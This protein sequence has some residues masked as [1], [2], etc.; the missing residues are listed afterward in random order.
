M[1]CWV[2]TVVETEPQARYDLLLFQYRTFSGSACSFVK[3]QVLKLW[4][5]S[6]YCSYL[7]PGWGSG[8]CFCTSQF[9][10]T[11]LC[12]PVQET[13]MLTTMPPQPHSPLVQVWA[14]LY[15]EPQA[16]ASNF[17]CA[18]LLLSYLIVLCLQSPWCSCVSWA[19]I[20]YGTL[21][22]SHLFLFL[23]LYCLGSLQRK[24]C[25]CFFF[26]PDHCSRC[27]L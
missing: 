22:C 24:F 27:T 11:W 14:F 20:C 4:L 25:E 19:S 3:M 21:Y 18:L 15:W 6:T 17:L 8:M 9:H 26:P 13:A 16:K 12:P 2:W 10:M 7:S 5:V 1:Q 23:N